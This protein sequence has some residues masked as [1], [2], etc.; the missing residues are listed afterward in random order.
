LYKFD[1]GY[2]YQTDSL[3]RITQVKGKELK[4][5]SWDRNTYQ[6]GKVANCGNSGDCGGHLIASMFGG[7]GEA[8]N[9]VPMDAKL[10]GSGGAWFQLETQWKNAINAGKKVEVNIQ[11]V[12]SGS[13]ARPDSFRVQYKIDGIPDV[14][15][16]YNTLTGLPE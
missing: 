6:Q 9:L 1:N 13:S 10:N 8:I 3:G 7:P 15:N 2:E 4:T 16:L 14:R 11:P 12:Y 5:D